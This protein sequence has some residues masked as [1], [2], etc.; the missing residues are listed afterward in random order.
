[1]EI[2][3]GTVKDVGYPEVECTYGKVDDNTLYYFI[4][5]GDLSNGNIIASTVLKEAIG[6]APYTSL[7]LIDK[8][9]NVLIPFEHKTI[10]KIKDKLLLAEKNI[11]TSE[12]V[13][14]ALSVKDSPENVQVLEENATKIKRQIINVMGMSGDFIFDNQYSEAGIYTEDGL[15]V[16]NGYYSYISELNSNYYFSTNIGNQILKFNPEMLEEQKSNEENSDQQSPLNNNESIQNGYN[17]ISNQSLNNE[18]QIQS[19]TKSIDMNLPPQVEPELDSNSDISLSVGEMEQ[20]DY[21]KPMNELA[22]SETEITSHEDSTSENEINDTVVPTVDT[23]DTDEMKREISDEIDDEKVDIE[24]F[25]EEKE[26][27]DNIPDEEVNHNEVES[28]IADN[29]LSFNEDRNIDSNLDMIEEN[30]LPRETLHKMSYQLTD[31]DIATPVIKDATQTIKNMIK[32]NG[33]LRINQDKLKGRIKV[34]ETNVDILNEDSLVKDNENKLLRQELASERQDKSLYKTQISN[35]EREN[36]KLKGA[37]ERQS[38]IV[39]ELEIQNTELRGQVSGLKALNNA[40]TEA[41]A[42]VQP[43]EQENNQDN[44]LVMYSDFNYLGNGKSRGKVA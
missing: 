14:K 38:A 9:G 24:D 2:L 10:R 23:K 32:E 31:E 40:I 26:L 19:E 5:D 15:N 11:P 13:V 37:L 7:G 39:K 41:N 12:S 22:S 8:K 16:A 21:D 18:Q 42:L 17:T 44:N 3:K 34:L 25:K 36:I 27:L 30:N 35:I 43:L 28:D 6:H 4:P 1:M 33:Q 20:A 29:E